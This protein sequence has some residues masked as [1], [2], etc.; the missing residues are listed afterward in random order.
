MPA[1]GHFVFE[2]PDAPTV[3]IEPSEENRNAEFFPCRD[4]AGGNVGKAAAYGVGIAFYLDNPDGQLLG[5][6]VVSEVGRDSQQIVSLDWNSTDVT[7]GWHKVYAV[8]DPA[9]LT[10]DADRSNNHGWF[11][12]G[13]LPDL[14][15]YSREIGYSANADG[16]ITIR[17]WVHNTG[18]RDATSASMALY[19]SLPSAGSVPLAVT[20]TDVPASGV[21]SASVTLSRVPHPIFYLGVKTPEGVD[22]RDPSNNVVWVESLSVYLPLLQ[23]AA[24]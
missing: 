24:P 23:Q 22:D 12:V 21:M 8:V 17:A 14:A 6:L 11:S 16:T 13:V 7:T 3:C 15:L 4:R 5:D 9:G 1:W 20:S 2:G 18:L 10:P 19:D